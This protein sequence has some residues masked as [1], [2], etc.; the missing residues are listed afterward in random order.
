MKRVTGKHKC[1]SFLSMDNSSPGKEA[2]ALE[3]SCLPS[4]QVLVL[5]CSFQ[6]LYCDFFFSIEVPCFLTPGILES[7]AFCHKFL[8]LK[9]KRHL[10][11][12]RTCHHP[13]LRW[14]PL[15]A[16][17]GGFSVHISDGT[18]VRDGTVAPLQHS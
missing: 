5:F 13:C 2:V 8:P 6:N 1:I 7:F 4:L 10:S 11:P 3:T 15:C 12:S 9:G 16:M 17:N 14:L 18:D